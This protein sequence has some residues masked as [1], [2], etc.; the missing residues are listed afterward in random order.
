[1]RQ[2]MSKKINKCD[3]CGKYYD[4]GHKGYCSKMCYDG[5]WFDRPR[6]IGRFY[7]DSPNKIYDNAEDR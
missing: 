2:E 7:G 6:T 3:F 5:D 1:M 4:K